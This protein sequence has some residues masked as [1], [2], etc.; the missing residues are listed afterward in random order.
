MKFSL[1]IEAIK[2]NYIKKDSFQHNAGN[3]MLL[4]P[5]T[6]QYKK[7]NL[8]ELES[9]ISS[10]GTFSREVEGKVEPKS[11][12]LEQYLNGV[13]ENVSM[14][15]ENKSIFKEFIMELF[16]YN[17]K[18]IN[19]HPKSL[20]FL[21]STPYNKKQG[22]FL[23]DILYKDDEEVT[24]LIIN[25]YEKEP[26][27]LLIK[28]LV[29][30]LPSLQENRT[31]RPRYKSIVPGVSEL[32]ME[33]LK[34]T[35]KREDLFLD[36]FEKLLKFYY[37]AY[38]AQAALVL[39]ATFKSDLTFPIDL[40]FAL[41]W[42]N[43]SKG[44]PNVD[45]GWKLVESNLLKLFS[46]ANALDLINHNNENVT[47]SYAELK[48]RIDRMDGEEKDGFI[49]EIDKLIRLYMNYINVPWDAFKVEK[50]FDNDCYNVIFRLFK[51]IN[52]QF[53][54][55][56]RKER[57][58]D[59]GTWFIEFCKLNFLK[60]RGRYGY[61]LNL[62][63]EHIIFL[64]KICIKDHE[65]IKLKDLFQEFKKRGVSLDNESKAK[66][67]QLFEKLN[68]LEKKSDSGDAQYVKRIL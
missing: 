40:Y 14:K 27:N 22:Q 6:T 55:S 52:Y 65:K 3:K 1:D 57:Q 43:T 66:L 61:I 48:N 8:V 49:E 51:M 54:E 50:P 42:E 63:E 11:F 37:F 21:E 62:T 9:F 64:T 19:F 13:S 7:S 20:S 38:M 53:E 12:S 60:L 59:Y 17:D 28:L 36:N 47:Y 32:F 23:F 45:Q 33:D 10:V 31:T 2:A 29:D 46:H 56:G 68:I 58:R 24:E 34:Y 15:I 67:T 5:F 18:P 26:N 4:F 30:N 41:D 16:F 25:I 44:R 39:N 35:L